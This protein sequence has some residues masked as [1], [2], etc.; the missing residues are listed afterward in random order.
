MLFDLIRRKKNYFT[1]NY[2]L[3]HVQKYENVFLES[4]DLF[5]YFR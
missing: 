2:L 5:D 4:S 1:L 3:F